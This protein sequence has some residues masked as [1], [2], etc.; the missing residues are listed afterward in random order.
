[1]KVHEY[2]DRKVANDMSV[3]VEYIDSCSG[4]VHNYQEV[5]NWNIDRAVKY[6]DDSKFKLAVYI[7]ESND[8]FDE[9]KED[10]K[11]LCQKWK[12]KYCDTVP[13]CN[14]CPFHTE[15]RLKC[16]K[17]DDTRCA[18]LYITK[19]MKNTLNNTVKYLET[20]K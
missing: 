16:S 20:T 12:A 11:T 6:I 5:R 7:S 17:F 13:D 9:M 15:Q 3:T 4:K 19:M 10:F 18:M 8:T 14:V 1:M 2:N